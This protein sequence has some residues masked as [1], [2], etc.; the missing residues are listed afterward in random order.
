MVHE[1]TAEHA[2]QWTAMAALSTAGQSP[3]S[4]VL[5]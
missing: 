3:C 2:S 1:L 4:V 5:R